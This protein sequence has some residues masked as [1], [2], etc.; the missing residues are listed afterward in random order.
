MHGSAASRGPPLSWLG[1][2]ASLGSWPLLRAPAVLARLAPSLQVHGHIDIV[3]L[4]LD[5]G[6]DVNKC[7]DEGLTPLSMCFLLHYPTTSFK[8]N[9]AERTVPEPQVSPGGPAP[10]LRVCTSP[11]HL[12]L[13]TS[14]LSSCPRTQLSPS[15]IPCP[16]EFQ[17]KPPNPLDE[18]PVP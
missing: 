9:I 4:L 6:A 11:A 12:S 13:G 15:P 7:T 18:T 2:G 3:N 5:N 10:W 8:P 16:L 14:L 17:Q 1:H